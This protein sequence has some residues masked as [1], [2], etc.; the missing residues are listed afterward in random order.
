LSVSYP[1]EVIRK[2]VKRELPWDDLKKMMSSFK[3]ADRFEKYLKV[4]QELTGWKEKIVLPLSEHLMII[5][6]DGNLV[7]RALCGYEFGDYKEN[8]KLKALIHVRRSDEEF[9]EIYLLP[10]DPAWCEIREFVCPGCG[11][12]LDVDAVPPGYPIIKEFEPDIETFYMKWLKK[13]IT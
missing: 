2:L 13:T 10:P 9:K 1:E 4:L 7:I 12:L 8:W 6:K 3:D 5:N 11:A